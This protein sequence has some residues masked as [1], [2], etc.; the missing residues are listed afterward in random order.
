M[1]RGLET[2]VTRK[3]GA[4]AGAQHAIAARPH[5]HGQSAT[6]VLLCA[7]CG[8][9]AWSEDVDAAGAERIRQPVDGPTRPA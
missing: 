2:R 5:G 7:V 8:V 1:R 4:G 3:E 6:A 9:R